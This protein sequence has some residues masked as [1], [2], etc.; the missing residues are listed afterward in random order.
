[1]TYMYL[2]KEAV[3][4]CIFFGKNIAPQT[5]L[6]VLSL[7]FADKEWQKKK[8]IH[9]KNRIMSLSGFLPRN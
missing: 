8:V 3:K 7:H 9:V 1:M 5:L 6:H 4:R 2:R